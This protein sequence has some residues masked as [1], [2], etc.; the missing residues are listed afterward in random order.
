[1]RD[2]PHLYFIH[3]DGRIVDWIGLD[4]LRESSLRTYLLDGFQQ[5]TL[6]TYLTA[7]LIGKIGEEKL[8]NCIDEVLRITGK[9]KP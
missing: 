3:P 9:A 5:V 7:Q 8:A 1:M 6:D 4:S 2:N